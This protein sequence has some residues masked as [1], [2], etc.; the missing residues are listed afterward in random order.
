MGSF[1]AVD[2]EGRKA[3]NDIITSLFVCQISKGGGEVSIVLGGDSSPC[4]PTMK[5]EPT[6]LIIIEVGCYA[7]IDNSPK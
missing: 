3:E 4:H 2:F 7:H 5:D 1:A 6:L